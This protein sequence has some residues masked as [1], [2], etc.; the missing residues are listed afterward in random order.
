MLE[1]ER[2][3]LTTKIYKNK[4]NIC[5]QDLCQRQYCALQR[6]HAHAI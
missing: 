4:Y 2:Y 1:I 3:K 5:I 6:M